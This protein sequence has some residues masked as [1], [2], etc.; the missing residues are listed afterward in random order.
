MSLPSCILLVYLITISDARYHEP[1]IYI[2]TIFPSTPRSPKW[3]LS[4]RFPYQ[5]PVYASPPYAL[6]ALT[7]AFFLDFITRTILG[8][9]YRTFS[10]SLCSLLHS[11][12]TLPQLII[13]YFIPVGHCRCLRGCPFVCPFHFFF[14]FS[15]LKFT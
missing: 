10:S 9:E 5:N 1:K 8:E 13:V 3:S 6:H 15:S 2:N 11:P 7:I 12:V 4:L 14:C